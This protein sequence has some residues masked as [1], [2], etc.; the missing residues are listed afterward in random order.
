MLHIFEDHADLSFQVARIIFEQIKTKPDSVICLASGESPLLAYRLLT[1]LAQTEQLDTT[2]LTLIALDEWLDILPDNPGSC[3]YFLQK[4]IIEPLNLTPD[5]CK[6]FNASADDLTV[7]C[8][9]MNKSIASRGGLD[10]II[11]GVGMNGHVGFNEPGVSPDLHAHVIALDAVTSSVGQ[12]YFNSKTK[13]TKGITLGLKDLQD[14][15]KA[16]LIASGERK[17]HIIKSALEGR[18]QVSVPASM[19]RLHANAT[20]MLDKKAASLLTH[21]A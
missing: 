14:A 20:I 19:I 18:I 17:S 8:A 5:Q 11:V 12:K 6:L 21:P 9:S 1:A 3:S 7:E 2:Q 16:I 15:K 13:L 4:N 10:L